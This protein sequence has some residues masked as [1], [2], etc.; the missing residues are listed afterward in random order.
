MCH[1]G[2]STSTSSAE[3]RSNTGMAAGIF[4]RSAA[5]AGEAAGAG[6]VGPGRQAAA[7]SIGN[8]ACATRTRMP[9]PPWKVHVAPPA[10]HAPAPAAWVSATL[11]ADLRGSACRARAGLRCLGRTSTAAQRCPAH[12]ASLAR[13]R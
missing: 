3:Y 2:S 4:L 12:N 7:G 5:A 13:R 10:S 6:R 9:V 1:M 8:A 11:A